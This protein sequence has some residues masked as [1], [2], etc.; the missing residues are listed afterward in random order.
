MSRSSS[1]VAA[2]ATWRSYEYQ[3]MSTGLSE[4]PNPAMSGSDDAVAGVEHRA[5]DLAPQEAPRRLAVPHHD[6]RAVALVD[7]G[8][9]EP[10]DLAVVGRPREARE[11]LEQLVGCADGVGH[12]GSM[13][14]RSSS[15]SSASAS[16]DTVMWIAC[17]S[18]THAIAFSERSRSSTNWNASAC[19]RER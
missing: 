16:R 18:R 2:I 9:P 1:S 10:V 19:R 3:S 8:E 17:G 7:V 11:T 15:G 14:T 6:R 12:G 5:G 4:R 13:F